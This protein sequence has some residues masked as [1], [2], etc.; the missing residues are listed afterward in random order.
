MNY[1]PMF[2]SIFDTGN[3][4]TY[5]NIKYINEFQDQVSNN[6]MGQLKGKAILIYE[7]YKPKNT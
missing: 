2:R 5:L 6:N 4:S 7:N 1:I 3:V